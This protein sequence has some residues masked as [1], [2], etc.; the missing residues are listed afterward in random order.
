MSLNAVEDLYYVECP[1][2]EKS[3]LQVIALHG[4]GTDGNGGYPSIRRI[5]LMSGFSRSTVQLALTALRD[6]GWLEWSRASKN[7]Q[8]IYAI[9]IDKIP[10]ID[11]TVYR[12]P[13]QACTDSRYTNASNHAAD[14]C[15][16]S[17]Y[18]VYRQAASRVPTAGNEASTLSKY[19]KQV[20]KDKSWRR[21]RNGEEWQYA[22][23][24]RGSRL[25]G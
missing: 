22:R 23:A 9:H 19:F 8:N 18:T 4:R 2:V 13:I 21:R 25:D 5:A 17:R 12:E 1:G 3:V 6:K 7:S 16:E 15:T 24:R 11:F 14:S 20:L 10:K